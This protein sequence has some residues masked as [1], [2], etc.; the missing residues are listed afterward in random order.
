MD[1]FDDDK[2]CHRRGLLGFLILFLFSKKSMHGQDIAN[3]I[4]KRKFSRTFSGVSM[5]ERHCRILYLLS[6]SMIF[7]L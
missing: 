4:A 3:E 1:E 7:Q 6:R 2:C 5:L